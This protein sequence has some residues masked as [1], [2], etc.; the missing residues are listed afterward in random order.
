MNYI[1]NA[2]FILFVLTA[3]YQIGILYD[4][5]ISCIFGCELI[6]PLLPSGWTTAAFLTG[7]YCIVYGFYWLTT[8]DAGLVGDAVA[9]S[10]MFFLGYVEFAVV[11]TGSFLIEDLAADCRKRRRAQAG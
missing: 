11:A 9:V 1:E 6:I 4:I 2:L 10:T 8:R 7:L 3:V 5:F